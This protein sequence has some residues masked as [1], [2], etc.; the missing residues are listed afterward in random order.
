MKKP[1]TLTLLQDL[2]HGVEHQPVHPTDTDA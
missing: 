1:E 2:S